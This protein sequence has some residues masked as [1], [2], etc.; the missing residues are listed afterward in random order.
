[1]YPRIEIHLGEIKYNAHAVTRMCKEKNIKVMGI[2]K[3]VCA[4]PEVVRAMTDGGVADLGDARLKN[5][6]DIKKAGFSLP[7]YL[8][9][10]PMM[11]EVPELVRIA[12]GSLNSEVSVIRAISSEAVKA[13]KTHNVILMVDVGDLREGVMPEDA[14]KTAGEVLDL[15]GVRLEGIG[16]N[17]GCYGGVIAT[18]ENTGCLAG[19]AKDIERRYGIK[20]ATISGGN[21]ETLQLM[22]EGGLARGVN[23][24][25]VGEAIL[26]GTDSTYVSPIPGLEQDTMILK[27]EVIESKTK[28]SVPIGEIGKNSF[29][30]VPVFEDKGDMRRAIV[31][32]G[33]QDC[34]IEGLTP[35]D[36]RMKIIGASSDHMIL[37]VTSVG[38]VKPGDIIGFKVTYSAMLSLMTSNYVYKKFID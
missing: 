22:R 33:K 21:S 5:I 36:E 23:Q 15:P 1:M 17:L 32:I 3:G 31:A 4:L 34:H 8:I 20:L 30:E 10:I 38:D 9:R 12:G 24:L 16:T 2:T 37:D 19:L 35:L 25:R 26:L 14:V 13:G 18:G 28:P 7:V 11:S 27:T 29:G 6:A